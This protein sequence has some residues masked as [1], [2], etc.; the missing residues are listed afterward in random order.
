M[1]D[2]V[3]DSAMDGIVVARPSVRGR[4]DLATS[5]AWTCATP[6]ERTSTATRGGRPS[7]GATNDMLE[8]DVLAYAGAHQLGGS[9]DEGRTMVA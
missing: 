7:G 1:V 5:R 4:R 6:T 2:V 3:V 9:G 8:I